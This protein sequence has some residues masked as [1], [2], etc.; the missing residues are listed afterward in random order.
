MS[1]FRVGRSWLDLL[2]TR[3]APKPT[4]S[5][6]GS[7]YLRMC[8]CSSGALSCYSVALEV[9]TPKVRSEALSL[10]KTTTSQSACRLCLHPSSSLQLCLE[11]ARRTA[12]FALQLWHIHR[13]W[14][15]RTSEEQ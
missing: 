14:L 15:A 6:S 1:H 4:L 9:A 3:S 2:P 5:S 12:T 11:C 7:A 13:L 10:R 8:C